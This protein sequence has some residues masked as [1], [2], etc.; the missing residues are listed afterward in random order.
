MYV[1]KIP[2]WLRLL[3]RSLI[4]EMPV[5]SEKKIY[6]TFDDGPHHE[7]TPFVLDQLKKYDA[8]ASFFC[9]G[10]NV[11]KHPD[12]YQRII[13][14]GHSIGNHTNNHL[15]GWKVK[16]AAYLA[17]IQEASEVIASD[18]FRPP[19]GRITR[20]VIRVLQNKV[21]SG[22]WIVDSLSGSPG[23]QE[24][25]NGLRST[26]NGLSSPVS[27]L[28]SPVLNLPSKIVMWTVLAGD[29][30]ITLSKEKCLQNVLKHAGN[31]SIVVFHDSTKAWERMSY[32][33]PK[34]LAYFTEQGYSFERL[35]D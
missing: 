12:I 20:G 25:E 6:L 32:A 19:Y 27:G 30:D 5:T 11:R 10:K 15:N 3:Y 24:S 33:L 28:R 14:E 18:L 26:V 21:D 13:A 23:V 35:P 2:W 9:I 31:G 34:V 8:K 1:V 4:W 17:N 7:A 16:D 29:F 22:K